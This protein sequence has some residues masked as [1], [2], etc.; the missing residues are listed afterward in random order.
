MLLGAQTK[1]KTK[2]KTKTNLGCRQEV[3][4]LVVD[5]SPGRPVLSLEGRD[6]LSFKILNFLSTKFE[7]RN[8]WMKRR[9]REARK[10]ATI[11]RKPL[12]F[13]RARLLVAARLRSSSKSIPRRHEV[14][15]HSVRGTGHKSRK[16]W[17]FP[18]HQLRLPML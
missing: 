9:V 14:E 2:T 8:T 18:D 10:V 11:L 15:T 1:T 5:P 16:P 4:E 3:V 13:D 6:F 12:L 17:G 7:K